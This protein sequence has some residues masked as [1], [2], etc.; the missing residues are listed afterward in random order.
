ML[1]CELNPFR[2]S[3]TCEDQAASHSCQCV[4]G[5]PGHECDVDCYEVSLKLSTLCNKCNASMKHVTVC[6]V[7]HDLT[8]AIL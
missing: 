4:N 8:S 3:G 5:Y 7:T 2:N 6:V 1:A